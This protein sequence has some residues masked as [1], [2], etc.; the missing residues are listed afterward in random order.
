MNHM[1]SQ[2][3]WHISEIFS[4]FKG[5]WI[6]VK[7]GIILQL[8]LAFHGTHGW[9]HSRP[10]RIDHYVPRWPHHPE[11]SIQSLP[12]L[13]HRS[14][15]SGDYETSLPNW[16]DMIYFF[17]NQSLMSAYIK[18]MVIQVKTI[19]FLLSVNAITHNP[20]KCKHSKFWQTLSLGSRPM[21][22]GIS[23]FH[24]LHEGRLTG[25]VWSATATDPSPILNMG[26]LSRF[27]LQASRSIEEMFQ[28]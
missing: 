26:R 23:P 22:I 13:G 7:N 2:M 5:G 17:S 10:H 3:R 1:S 6:K 24:R 25:P 12:T 27:R 8:I 16:T 9:W 19:N 15:S 14:Q 11:V 18:K 20:C 4:Y 28:T 21:R